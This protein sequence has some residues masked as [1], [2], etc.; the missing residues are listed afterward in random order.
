M[1][2]HTEG[3]RVRERQSDPESAEFDV[4][5]VS[6]VRL[7]GRAVAYLSERC[8]AFAFEGSL[9]DLNLRVSVTEAL[10]NAI[11][12]GNRED[13]EKTVRMEARIDPTAITVRVIDGGPGFDPDD[14]PD[15]T[16]ED[17][18]ESPRGRGVFLLRRLMDEV[19]Y[20][21]EGNVV[22][23]VLRREEG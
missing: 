15:P 13:P 7:I 9:V 14:V 1:R 5:L 11:L 18:L 2:E 17:R 12:Y 19:E 4:D 8:R 21:E 22:R 6:D 10:A 3:I 20:N 16:H 23:L